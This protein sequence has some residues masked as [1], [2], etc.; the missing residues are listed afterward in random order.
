M[1]RG[2]ARGT[3]KSVSILLFL[4]LVCTVVV[5]VHNRY[6]HYYPVRLSLPVLSDYSLLF[7]LS[8]LVFFFSA[9]VWPVSLRSRSVTVSENHGGVA[10]T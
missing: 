4:L 3:T 6:L 7:L 1:R 9:C 2:V 10:V 8:V 5:F